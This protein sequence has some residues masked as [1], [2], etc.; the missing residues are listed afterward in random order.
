[1]YLIILLS[2]TETNSIINKLLKTPFYFMH[3]IEY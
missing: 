2:K 1:M 3:Q